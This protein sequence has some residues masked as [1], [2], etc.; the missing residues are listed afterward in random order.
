MGYK[1]A[2]DELELHRRVDEV[3]FYV[4]DPIGVANSPAARDEYYGYLP[5]VFS[6]L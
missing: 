1:L 2:D 5:I 4:W 6:M 3:L